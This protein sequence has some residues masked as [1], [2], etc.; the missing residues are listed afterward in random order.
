MVN[1]SIYIQRPTTELYVKIVKNDKQI[2]LIKGLTPLEGFYQVHLP[3][4]FFGSSSSP[5]KYWIP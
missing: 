4:D 1:Q 5:L 3:E 2:R